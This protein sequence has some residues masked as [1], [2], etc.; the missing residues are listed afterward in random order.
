VLGRKS[1]EDC[2]MMR[3][4]SDQQIRVATAIVIEVT[5][6]VDRGQLQETLAS[7]SCTMAFCVPDDAGCRYKIAMA[8]IGRRNGDR[9]A[10]R[11]T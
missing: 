9:S 7:K 1:A 2:L 3:G 5:R 11:K 8:C 10:I 4:P 6:H